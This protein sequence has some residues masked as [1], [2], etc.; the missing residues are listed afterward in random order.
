MDLASL[1]KRYRELQRVLHPDRHLGGS[2][3]AS[4]GCR[5][6]KP[7]RSTEAWRLVRDPIRRAEGAFAPA[8]R[9]GSKRVR[10]PQADPEFLMEMMEQREALSEARA[11]GDPAAVAAIGERDSKAARRGA[12]RASRPRSRRAPPNG[13]GSPNGGASLKKSCRSRRASLL[14]AL[15]RRSECHRRRFQRKG[16]RRFR[17]LGPWYFSRFFDPQEPRRARSASISGRP[18]PRGLRARWSADGHPGLRSR[19]ARPLGGELRRTRV[20]SSLGAL[21]S[22]A[23]PRSPKRRSS[24]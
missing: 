11:G 20:T 9:A 10:S 6:V 12:R 13:G 17:R 18:T 1:E 7:S 15:S 4:A 8:R 22:G 5:S 23:R 19:S 21:R 24:A 14:P 16:E 2:P 3:A